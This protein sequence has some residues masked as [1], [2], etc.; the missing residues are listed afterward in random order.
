MDSIGE[1]P[2]VKV[3]LIGLQFPFKVEHSHPS[4]CVR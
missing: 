1:V 4:T 2:V 3:D